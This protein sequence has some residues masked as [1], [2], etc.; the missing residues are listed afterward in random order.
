MRNIHNHLTIEYGREMNENFCRWEKLAMKMADFSNHRRFSLRCLS[1]GLIPVSI[2]LRTNIRT[3]KG[4]FIIR[5]AEKSLL[6]ERI[7][8]INNTIAMLKMQ[9]DTCINELEI[10]LDKKS[11]D[12]CFKFIESKRELRHQQTM[13]CQIRKFERLQN[14]SQI[15]GGHSKQHGNHD[16]KNHDHA[17]KTTI[18]K[19]KEEGKTSHQRDQHQEPR[20]VHNISSTP[21]RDTQMKVLSRGPSFAIMPQNLPVGEYIASIENACSKLKQGKADELRG[22]IKAIIKK[23]NTPKNNITKE[24]KKALVE[25]R[26]DS[27]KTILTADKGVSLVVMNKEDHQK[28]AL[29]L[30]DQPTY[31][32]ITTD[33]TSKYKNRL[34]SLLKTIKSEGRIDEVTYKKLYPT[35][36]GTPN[37][38]GL[39]KVHKAGM[40][41][42][43]TVSSIGAVSYE[44]S[45]ELSRILKPLVGQSP[46]HVHNNKEFLHQLKDQ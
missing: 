28:K 6:N 19:N 26:K 21:L 34:I 17:N 38:Y 31:K 20:W 5:K 35:G 8:S 24:E 43:P 14:Y 30:L 37:F 13:K 7:R 44:T 9:V 1:K 29:E 46:Y 3:P 16:H 4:Q 11:M 36:A 45:K 18:I 10:T 33:P 42:R 23:I 25:L 41:L 32:T 15:N 12:E 27:N 39:P 2:K 22:E 40:P